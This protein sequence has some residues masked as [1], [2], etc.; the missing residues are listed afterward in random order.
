MTSSRSPTSGTNNISIYAANVISFYL[1]FATIYPGVD[2]SLSKWVT[3][4][5]WTWT[6]IVIPVGM[7][8][9]AMVGL[10]T[11]ILVYLKKARGQQ[12]NQDYDQFSDY[13]EYSSPDY[14]I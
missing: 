5:K 13:T 14:G 7:S 8:I 6:N 2:L 4:L 12:T 1:V 10:W 11:T 9:L 3:I